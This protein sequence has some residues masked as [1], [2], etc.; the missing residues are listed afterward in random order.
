MKRIFG[1]IYDETGQEPLM[2]VHVKYNSPDGIKGTTTD[3]KG[4]YSLEFPDSISQI[5]ISFVGYVPQIVEIPQQDKVIEYRTSLQ[6]NKN[7]LDVFTVTAVKSDGD[8]KKPNWKRIG[9]TSGAGLAGL[10]LILFTVK[11]LKS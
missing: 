6:K 7:L 9:V 10:A 5:E 11:S 3:V 2:A 4:A 1:H 8:T